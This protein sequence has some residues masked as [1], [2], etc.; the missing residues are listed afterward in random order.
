MEGNKFGEAM[1][2]YLASLLKE[3]DTIKFI[4]L[5][6]NLLN[7]E[8]RDNNSKKY[9]ELKEFVEALSFNDTVL[10]INLTNTGL[11]QHCSKMLRQVFNHNKTLILMDLDGNPNMA[12]EDIV[13]IQDRLIENKQL[14]D[15]ERYKEFIERKR[16]RREEDISGVLL[17]NQQTKK[18]RQEAIELNTEAKRKQLNN[19]W[20]EFLTKEEAMKLKL[21]AKYEKEAK[22]KGKKKK[23]KAAAP[24]K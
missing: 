13:Y 20:E 2:S 21:M 5:E 7:E 1:L 24:K 10:C 19:E 6:D 18:L 9:P 14:H 23:K 11:D 22:M 8:K 3:N 4:D 12:L 16:M 17:L 15:D